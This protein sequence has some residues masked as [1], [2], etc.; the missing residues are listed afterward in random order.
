ME[1]FKTQN[2]ENEKKT[3]TGNR[4]C[5]SFLLIQFYFLFLENEF[6]KN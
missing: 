1:H 6:K 4:D 5:F 2:E 3:T